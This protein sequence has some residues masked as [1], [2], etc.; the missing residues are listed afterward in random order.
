MLIQI[1]YRHTQVYYIHIQVYYK[2]G[3]HIE[4]ARDMCIS[5][6]HIQS[7]PLNS[8]FR[9]PTKFVLIMNLP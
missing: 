1:N 7:S 2:T 3:T 9:E 8:N 4:I 5:G 6:K